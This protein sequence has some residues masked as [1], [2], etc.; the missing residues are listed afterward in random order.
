RSVQK[1][2]LRS[3]WLVLKP[4]RHGQEVLVDSLTDAIRRIKGDLA[5]ILPDVQMTRLLDKLGYHGRDRLFTPAITTYLTL[6]RALENS[7]IS[8]LRHLSGLEFSPSAY[9]QAIQR[10]P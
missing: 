6:Q 4:N 10:L 2:N 1:K 9:C 5:A 7:S 3:C 8:G